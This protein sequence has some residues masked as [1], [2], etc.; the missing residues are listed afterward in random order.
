MD[1]QTNVIHLNN[2]LFLYFYLSFP[3]PKN[4]IIL[5]SWP[6]GC[7]IWEALDE[8]KEVKERL[9]FDSGVCLS[10]KFEEMT[11]LKFKI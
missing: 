1:C 4:K 8:T 9:D 11:S 5:V 3:K 7:S 2:N 10:P 6:K